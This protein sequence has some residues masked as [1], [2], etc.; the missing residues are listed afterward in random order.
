MK[1]PLIGFIFFAG[2]SSSQTKLTTVSAAD[3]S[4]LV[5]PNS[6]VSLFAPNIATGA[7]SATQPPPTPLPL[8]L[9][10]VNVV[11][12]DSGGN[13]FVASLIAVT[14][15]QVNAILPANMKPGNGTVSLTASN[16]EVITG[17]VQVTQVAPSIFTAD[18]SGTWLAAAQVV[19]AHSDGTQ[20]V[21]GSVATCGNT[22]VFNGT[23]Y[24]NCVP[25]PVDIGTAADE[26]V[27]ELFGTGIR[28]VSAVV[29][30]NPNCLCDPVDVAPPG[31]DGYYYQVLY[32]G[33]QG[34]GGPTSFFGLD[35]VNI[36]LPHFLAG[37]GLVSFDVLVV[38]SNVSMI[39][40]VNT[41]SVYI[42]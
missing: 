22:P 42:K 3:Y 14:P 5:A 31:Y 7:F 16:G 35:Q 1:L 25:V 2:I 28:N 29:A 24:S 30:S 13:T 37:A 9:G 39:A 20:T 23:G 21:I 4:Y 41:V 8:T 38:S 36:V 19:I 34:S 26:A 18:Q 40:P 10:K 33:P 11:F 12:T 17:S 15:D 6:V 32:F 27:L